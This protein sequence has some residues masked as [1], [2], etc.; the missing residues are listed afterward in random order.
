GFTLQLGRRD[1][2]ETFPPFLAVRLLLRPLRRGPAGPG[3][4]ELD[5]LRVDFIDALIQF[6]RDFGARDLAERAGR[7][8]FIIRAQIL[9]EF[10]RRAGPGVAP[11]YGYEGV[12]RAEVGRSQKL[13]VGQV[14]FFSDERELQ[15]RQM[16]FGA[17]A[18]ERLLDQFARSRF[19]HRDACADDRRR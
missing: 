13:R 4:A 8:Q 12:Q 10:G 5:E 15:S 18:F 7:P 17:V 9:D 11:Q 19:A 16:L 3:F 1:Q 2:R 6:L 14:E